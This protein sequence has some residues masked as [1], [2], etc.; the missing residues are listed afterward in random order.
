MELKF[1]ETVIKSEVV[2]QPHTNEL[3]HKTTQP[4]EDLILARN[5]ELRKNP[6]AINDLSFGRQIASIPMIMYEKAIRDGYNLNCRDSE[7][8]QKEMVRFLKSTDGKLCLIQ[9]KN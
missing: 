7:I 2:L 6:G 9:D 5:S 3:F 1:N 8:A 4:T